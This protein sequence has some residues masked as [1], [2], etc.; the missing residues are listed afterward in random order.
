MFYRHLKCE[1]KHCIEELQ[2]NI[3]V[4]KR[5]KPKVLRLNLFGQPKELQ[6]PATAESPTTT[7]KLPGKC[8]YTRV[9]TLG[10]SPELGT[11]CTATEA[12][13]SP[14]SSSENCISSSLS[15]VPKIVGYT[16]KVELPLIHEPNRIDRY[17]SDSEGEIQPLSLT[18][19]RF[20]QQTTSP[21]IKEVLHA[22]DDEFLRIIRPGKSKYGSKVASLCSICQHKAP[23][24]GKPPRGFTFSELQ[25]ATGGF[26]SANFLAEGGFGSVHRGVLPDGQVIA[27]K[28]HK[29]VSSQGDREFCAEVEILSRAQH[30]NVVMLIGFCIQGDRRLLV[31]DFVCNGSLDLHLYGNHR[32]AL[33]WHSRK[34]IATGAARGLRYLHEECRVGCII[35]RDMRPNNILITH[36]FEPLVRKF[37]CIIT[38]L[39]QKISQHSPAGFLPTNTFTEFPHRRLGILGWRDGSPMERR[40]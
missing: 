23:Q 7:N 1:E 15:L 32:D 36:D 27:V 17:D 21:F 19:L 5:S 33:S 3:V 6:C 38:L 12:G 37:Q 10:S 14:A 31:Y 26:S 2:C 8:R 30:K 24:F 29:L 18:S 16:Q 20:E 25:H 11:P 34:K 40:G 35:H 28:Q 13:T 22:P 9:A 39:P 4:M